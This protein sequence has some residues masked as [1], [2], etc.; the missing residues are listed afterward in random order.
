MRV[1]VGVGPSK[2]LWSCSTS[3]ATAGTE[4]GTVSVAIA[5]VRV[6]G[7]GGAS[8]GSGNGMGGR[9]AEGMDVKQRW[10]P[11]CARGTDAREARGSAWGVEG[12]AEKCL[13]LPIGVGPS[14]QPD[15]QRGTCR[16]GAG[17]WRKWL[18]FGSRL[19][20]VSMALHYL[21]HDRQ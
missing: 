1:G 21:G 14:R 13:A 7:W 4:E 18:A 8:V 12:F 9:A 10:R 20:Y 17:K 5:S 3:S 6:T 15:S 19:A 2:A 16:S 11:R